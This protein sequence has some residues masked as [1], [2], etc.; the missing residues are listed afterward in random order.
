M[1]E[2]ERRVERTREELEAEGDV[3]A[4]YLETLLDIADLDGDLDVQV[5]HDR[6]VVSIV[7]SEEG[8][9]PRRLVGPGAQVLEALQELARLAV[10]T[11][12]G[13][14]TRL[15]VDVAGYRADRRRA[16]EEL[17][18][19]TAAAV[20]ESGTERAL[21]P[22]TAFERKV[23]HDRVLAAGLVSTSEGEEPNRYVVVTPARDGDA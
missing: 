23:V 14:R 17:A 20:K 8:A 18:D 9:V 2:G 13:E 5:E 15:M 22:M 7:D 21:E 1:S 6:A 11:E 19:R 12:T 16:L 4:D 10:Q 3:A